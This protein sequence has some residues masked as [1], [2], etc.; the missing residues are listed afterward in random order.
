MNKSGILFYYNRI[1]R[2]NYEIVISIKSK[3][4]I[5]PIVDEDEFQEMIDK[6]KNERN[7]LILKFL[8]DTGV[9]CSELST[10][11]K[12]DM[13]LRYQ[14]GIIYKGKGQKDR[15]FYYSPELAEEMET[16]ISKMSG[17]EK[18]CKYLI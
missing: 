4:K 7:K 14:K 13:K 8:Y 6:A 3:I 11:K 9:R 16:F 5:H 12:N 18:A 1:L 15:V 10:I 2:R 17:K